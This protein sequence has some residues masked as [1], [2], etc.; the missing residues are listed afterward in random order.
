MDINSAYVSNTARED[1]ARA[2]R[3]AFLSEITSFLA[4]RPNDLLSFEEVQKALPLQG[5]IYR[6]VRQVP[7]A[8]IQGSV[9]RYQD[10][11]RN[12]LPTQAHTRPRWEAIDR[13][14]LAQATL[15]AIQVY[16]VGDVYFVK[17]GNHRVSVARSMGQGP[18]SPHRDLHDGAGVHRRRSD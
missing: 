2:R 10:F 12:F 9:D 17:D 1:F 5:Q 8:E 16:Q 18:R 3:R 14:S 6:G 13:A 7:V 4:R 15:P 11:D